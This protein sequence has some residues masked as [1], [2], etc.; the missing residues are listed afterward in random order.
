MNTNEEKIDD[1]LKG[2]K[3]ILNL[4][5][6]KELNEHYVNRETACQFFGYGASNLNKLLK[7]GEIS[8]SKIGRRVFILKES[9]NDYLKKNTQS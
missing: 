4:L 2:Q 3:A 6:Q 9:I 5:T 1:L 7:S 8:H